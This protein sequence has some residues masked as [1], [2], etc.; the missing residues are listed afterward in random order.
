MIGWLGLLVARGV[1][2]DSLL[3]VISGEFGDLRPSKRPV[4]MSKYFLSITAQMLRL[5]VSIFNAT[6]HRLLLPGPNASRMFPCILLLARSS[7]TDIPLL[8]PCLPWSVPPRERVLRRRPAAT[9][10]PLV[11]N[12]FREAFAELR[13]GDTS[14]NFS[15]GSISSKRPSRTASD[16]SSTFIAVVPS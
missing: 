14:S 2:D 9:G 7:S 5:K 13:I 4:S 16:R 1:T 12:A 6:R 8:L 3:E 11:S 15:S 10:L